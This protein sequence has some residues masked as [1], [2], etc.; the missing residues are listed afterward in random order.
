MRETDE[1]RARGPRDKTG[2][3]WTRDYVLGMILMGAD[4]I[5]QDGHVATAA[6]IRHLA[7]SWYTRGGMRRQEAGTRRKQPVA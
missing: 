6:E 3:A 2:A 4:A 7:M 1:G 5:A